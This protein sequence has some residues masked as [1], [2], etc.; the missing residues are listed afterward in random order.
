MPKTVDELQRR[1]LK[2]SAVVPYI[3]SPAAGLPKMHLW[4]NA[5]LDGLAGRD[6][7]TRYVIFSTKIPGYRL[8]ANLIRGTSLEREGMS[9][10]F[11]GALVFL[12]EYHYENFKNMPLWSDF[13]SHDEKRRAD[14]EA[15]R[16]VRG[17]ALGVE[18][19]REIVLSVKDY[20]GAQRNW[21]K[22][23]AP[24]SALAN[25]L[26]EVAD[27]PAVRLIEGER[28]AILAL[29]LRVSDLDRA[30]TFLRESGMLDTTSGNEVR[31]DPAKIYGLDIRLV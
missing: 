5:F 2:C 20:A 16:A 3:E 27:G 12:V 18:S 24:V 9:R 31:I 13:K 11:A 15:L 26:W 28:D 14:A 8:I 6:F 4:S 29:V 25:G 1:G 22:F 23:F 30:K 21:N 7:W 10:L 19:V 17:G